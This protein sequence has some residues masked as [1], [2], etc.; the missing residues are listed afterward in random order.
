M[1]IK[2]QISPSIISAAVGML[3]PFVP[4]ISPTSLIAALETY[5]QQH[6]Q[7]INDKPKKPYTIR[8]VCELLGITKPTVYRMFHDGS[9][10]K[11][12]IGGTTRIPAD[13][14]LDIISGK[15]QDS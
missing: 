11:L 4:D 13:E 14:I 15:S 8:E 1:K 10:T 7:N 2:K 6:A 12:K 3:A 9:L 5:D